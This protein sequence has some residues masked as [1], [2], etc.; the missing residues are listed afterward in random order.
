MVHGGARWRAFHLGRRVR[1]G[2]TLCVDV[3]A[4]PDSCPE[5]VTLHFTGSTKSFN[6][7]S[8]P[9]RLLADPVT[10]RSVIFSS[11]ARP[12]VKLTMTRPSLDFSSFNVD[13][14]SLPPSVISRVTRQ[15]NPK[16][17]CFPDDSEKPDP[18]R[19]HFAT[20]FTTFG[21]FQD[22]GCAFVDVSNVV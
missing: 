8:W 3:F 17:T 2:V 6:R 11:I 22:M 10:T 20:L 7:R 4:A 9:V 13:D 1:S 16:R 15:T 18:F 12:A 5:V 21:T 19:P 14:S